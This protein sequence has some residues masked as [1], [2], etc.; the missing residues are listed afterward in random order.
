MNVRVPSTVGAITMELTTVGPRAGANQ[1]NP[2]V[3]A[4][5]SLSVG[6][7]SPIALSECWYPNQ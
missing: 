3:S 5:Q 1:G 4:P 7:P 6:A 2:L